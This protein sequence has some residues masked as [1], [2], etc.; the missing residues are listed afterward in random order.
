MDRKLKEECDKCGIIFFTSP[1]DLKIIDYIDK[2]IPAYKIGSGDI[3]YLEII[4]KLHRKINHI[5]SY[6]FSNIEDVKR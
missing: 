1:Y 4:K 3:T 5:S 6:W 2:F